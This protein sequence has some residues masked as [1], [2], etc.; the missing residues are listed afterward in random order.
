MDRTEKQS[1]EKQL[2]WDESDIIL[3]EN[4]IIRLLKMLGLFMIP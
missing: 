1:R 2:C 4:R 3:T